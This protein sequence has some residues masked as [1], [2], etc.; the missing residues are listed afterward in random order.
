MLSR[1][2][3]ICLFLLAASPSWAQVVA[4]AFTV[5]GVEVDVTA[6]DASAAKAQGLD[7]AQRQAFEQLLERLT[8]ASDRARLPRVDGTNYVRDYAVDQERASAVRYIATLSV[9]FNA[10]AVRKLLHDANISFT[11]ARTRPVVVVPVLQS[12]G[13]AVLWDDP[14]TGVVNPWRAAWAAATGGGLV[15]LAIPAGDLADTQALTVE[16][17]LANDAQHLAVMGARWRTSDVLTMVAQLSD[18]GKRLNVTLGGLA[19]TLRPLDSVSYDLKPGE[20]GDQMLARAV[21]DLGRAIDAGYKQTSQMRFERQDTMPALVSLTGL[22]DWL[23]A[24]E[25]LAR[26][27]PIASYDVVSLSRTEAALQLHILG[28]PDQVAQA[29]NDAGLN[30]QF[31]DGIWT[32]HGPAKK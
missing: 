4:D 22:D 32:L 27:A 7:Q 26:V 8:Q 1:P 30:P 5:R 14:A 29:L 12:Q 28:A 20:T 17:A 18:D 3:L 13:K 23:F 10:S 24:R 9:R 25:R 2:F 19:G 16:Q 6:S 15:P 21:R 31:A 11:D